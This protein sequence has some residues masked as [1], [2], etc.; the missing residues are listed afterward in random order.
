MH[1]AMVRVMSESFFGST[2]SHKDGCTPLAAQC[3]QVHVWRFSL[4]QRDDV[5]ARLF[6]T[7]SADEVARVARLR[8]PEH[9][10]KAIVAR[11]VL[12]A[13][14]GEYLGMP[15]SKLSFCYGEVGKPAL[16]FPAQ[17]T[18]EF[19]LSHS[20]EEGI[21]AITC[22]RRLGI[23]IEYV[24]ETS[25]HVGLADRFFSPA[26]ARLLE[27]IDP[28][29]RNI[30]F[31]HTWVQK[32]AYLK[33]LGHGLRIP[34][35]AF[36]VSVDPDLNTRLIHVSDEIKE[37]QAAWE[38]HRLDVQHNYIG[39]LVVDGSGLELTYFDWRT[40]VRASAIDHSGKL[41]AEGRRR[42]A[43]MEGRENYGV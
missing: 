11:G 26:E 10:T 4:V 30:A 17:T 7:L 35:N 29:R 23:D 13:I 31:Y 12:R 20:H 40:T 33:A 32:E 41:Q 25:E 1:H 27:Q 9:K 14:L 2:I 15:A 37:E 6:A 38:I 22:G 21:L 5:T 36:S 19:N 8:F 39:A 34:L 42:G 24:N 28:D 43:H 16:R 3:P 18:L